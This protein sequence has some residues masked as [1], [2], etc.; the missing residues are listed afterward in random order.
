MTEPTP[1]TTI[2]GDLASLATWF[3]VL[4]QP[5]EP[6]LLEE[7]SAIA[8]TSIDIADWAGQQGT[9][10]PHSRAASSDLAQPL[11]C[12]QSWPSPRSSTSP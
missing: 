10:S 1:P 2:D 7:L 8:P 4:D 6:S 3:P 12:R 11:K 9:P 5:L